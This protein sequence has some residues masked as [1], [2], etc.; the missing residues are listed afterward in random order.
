M[1]KILF[2]RKK[3]SQCRKK[4]LTCSFLRMWKI[5]DINPMFESKK[6]LPNI[7]L[8]AS[9]QKSRLNLKD[10]SS[11][12][13]MRKSDTTS[14]QVSLDFCHV[15][16]PSNS[17]LIS[18]KVSNLVSSNNDAFYILIMQQLSIK[19][20]WSF[21]YRSFPGLDLMM[22]SWNFPVPM[23]LTGISL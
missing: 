7:S 22:N 16:V 3:V 12:F 23:S 4:N 18:L 19:V 14:F 8:W 17:C 6:I 13:F 20:C 10:C 11:T 2:F 9:Y 1:G 21:C 15:R 5:S